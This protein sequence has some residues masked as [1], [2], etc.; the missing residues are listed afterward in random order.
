MP[1]SQLQ[2]LLRYP[3][4]TCLP[5]LVKLKG[6]TMFDPNK[7]VTV[8][9]DGKSFSVKSPDMV[10]FTKENGEWKNKKYTP[11][12]TAKQKGAEGPLVAA[13][14]SNHIYVYGTADNPSNEELNAR[15]AQAIEAATWATTSGSYLNTAFVFPRVVSD[16]RLR[17]SDY[18][19]CNLVLFGTKETNA[20]IAQYADKLP[21]HLDENVKDYG[22]VYIFPMNGKYILVNS[23]LPWW[24]H[25]KEGGNPSSVLDGAGKSGYLSNSTSDFILFKETSD[26][27]VTQGNFDSN[28]DLPKTLVND[29]I[30]TSIITVSE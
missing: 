17:Q 9:V 30:S 13:I 29:L 3:R 27:I 28:W 8:K 12:L 19:L 18:D 15:M 21:M 1:S 5:S 22:L 11:G 2:M 20:I 14:N 16:Q 23:G 7:R 25:A 24:T 6:H 4:T 10:S 26:N